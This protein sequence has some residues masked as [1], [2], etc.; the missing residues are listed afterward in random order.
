M[1]IKQLASGQQH[2][3]FIW[4]SKPTFDLIVRKVDEKRLNKDGNGMEQSSERHIAAG[5]S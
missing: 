2:H 3:W 1:E 4:K 5:R